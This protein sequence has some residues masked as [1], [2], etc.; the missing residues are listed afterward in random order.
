MVDFGSNPYRS[1][2]GSALISNDQS[3]LTL[4]SDEEFIVTT[5][6][7][8]GDWVWCGLKADND[9]IYSRSVYGHGSERTTALTMGNAHIRVPAGTTLKVAGLYPQP[10]TSSC[11]YYVDGYYARP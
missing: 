11:H 6:I 5:F 4:S 10:H 1:F 7:A 3:L 8:D 2:T 9:L